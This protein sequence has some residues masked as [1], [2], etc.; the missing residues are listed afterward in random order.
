MRCRGN[1]EGKTWVEGARGGSE[2]GFSEKIGGS[3][4]G[5]RVH[6][7]TVRGGSGSEFSKKTWV[8][9]ARGENARGRVGERV[10]AETAGASCGVSSQKNVWRRCAGQLGKRGCSET[11][12]W[13]GERNCGKGREWG[14]VHTENVGMG[15]EEAARVARGAG[16]RGN[17]A[18]V[19]LGVGSCGETARD[20]SGSWFTRKI[21]RGWLE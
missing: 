5:G 11:V 7:E 3:G 1:G 16:S 17:G 2:S 19:R 8:E 9:G 4:S 14:R 18:G 21:R 12:R 15:R 13:L 10:R 20:G 6:A